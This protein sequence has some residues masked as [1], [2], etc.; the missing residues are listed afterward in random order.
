MLD[1]LG[2][3]ADALERTRVR[4]ANPT[5]D[6]APY[7][8]GALLPGLLQ[9]L[10]RNVGRGLSGLSLFE[11][12]RVVIPAPGRAIG[13][14]RLPVDRRPSDDE[15]AS[16]DAGLPAQPRR[17]AV[18]STGKTAR[19]GWFGPG[20]ESQWLDAIASVRLA[21]RVID[22][23]LTVRAAARMPWHPGRCAELLVGDELIGYA[24]ELH[25][26]VCAALD[27]PPRVGAMEIGI[28][29]LAAYSEPIV[30][31]PRVSTFPLAREDLAFVVDEGVPAADL[32]AVSPRLPG[33]LLEQLWLVD[34]YTGPQVG[35]GRKSLADNVTLRAADHTLSVEELA[36]VRSRM[37]DAAGRKLG[38]ESSG[39]HCAAGERAFSHAASRQR[40][41]PSRPPW[42]T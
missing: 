35:E 4:L 37:V 33:G 9:A 27:L 8:R 15:L 31:A 25:P 40:R 29:R 13:T 20:R 23:P 2:L 22:A 3:P 32:A 17:L 41:L 39:R 18:V 30:P 19:D 38:A 34:V 36:D 6:E 1:A 12:G 14:P 21:A 24:G 5:S 11:L 42:S 7:L 16:L 10:R 28:E 26:R